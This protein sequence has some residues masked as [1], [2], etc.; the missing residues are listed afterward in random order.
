[1]V[2]PGAELISDTVNWAMNSR[3]AELLAGSGYTVNTEFRISY[4]MIIMGI[5]ILFAA[6]V[7]AVGQNLSEEQKYTI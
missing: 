7:F 4:A 6:E 5:L 2:V 1:M 3:A